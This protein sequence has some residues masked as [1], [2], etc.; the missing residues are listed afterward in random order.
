VVG[1]E[2]IFAGGEEFGELYLSW[3]AVGSDGVEQII[4]RNGTAG[5]QRSPGDGYRLH[6]PTKRNLFFEQSVSRGAVLGRLVGEG[7]THALHNLS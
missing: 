2:C 3:R 1:D 5:R 6:G 4:F 7:E